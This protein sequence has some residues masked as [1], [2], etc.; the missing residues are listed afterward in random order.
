MAANSVERLRRFWRTRRNLRAIARNSR[1]SWPS[2]APV[3][4]LPRDPAGPPDAEI[5]AEF[6]RFPLWHYA[7]SFQGGLDFA[8]RH[9]TP[10]PL[11]DDPA[12]PLQRFRHFMPWL[13]QAAGGTLEGKRVLDIACN[14]GF[15]S[16]QCALL[17]AREVVGFDARQELVDQANLIKRIVGVKNAHFRL[18][19]LW[20]MTPESLG[21]TFDVVLILGILYHVSKPVEALGLTKAMSR[22]IV[23]LDTSVFA[24]RAPLIHLRWEEPDDILSASASGVSMVPSRQS[25]EMILRH[26]RYRE[27]TEIPLRTRDMPDDYLRGNRASWLIRV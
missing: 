11:A 24:A 27:W 25:V 26:H 9:A 21:G 15:W 6:A 12:R 16:I 22:D 2:A 20:N 17:G 4:P 19:D 3:W 1:R 5:R 7:Y 13:L 10:I 8:V 18:H 23:L 14:S